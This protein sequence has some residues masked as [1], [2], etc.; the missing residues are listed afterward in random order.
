MDEIDF[1]NKDKNAT[2]IICAK[3]KSSYAHIRANFKRE[4]YNI[5][6]ET[7]LFHKK[8]IFDFQM[9]L[10]DLMPKYIILFDIDLTLIRYAC[11]F[12]LAHPGHPLR[13]PGLIK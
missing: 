4:P 10:D 5:D 7:I 13:L 9:I 11:M 3:Y 8:S 2:L 1:K 6:L 12:K